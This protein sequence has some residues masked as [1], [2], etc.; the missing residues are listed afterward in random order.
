MGKECASCYTENE[1]SA[2]KCKSCGNIFP[3][4]EYCAAEKSSSIPVLVMTDMDKKSGK[5]IRINKTCV[6]GRKGDI[7][8]EF[9]AEDLYISEYHCKIILE[10]GGYKIEHM[11]TATN[12]TKINDVKLS[13]GISQSIRNG[14]FL[15]IADKTFEISL[16]DESVCEDEVPDISSPAN[17][18]SIN[19]K[20]QYIISCPKC[21]YE[22][23]VQDMDSRIN[24]CGNC[25]DDYDK[26]EISKI[27]AKVKYAN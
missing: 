14:D 18:N 20:P 4:S 2:A 5:E 9:F 8:T 13:K 10:K 26:Y 1:D 24:E 19:E 22:Y 21:G 7:E 27:R 23:E 6:I 16:C 3:D 15:T 25:G 17:E 11:P 12:P